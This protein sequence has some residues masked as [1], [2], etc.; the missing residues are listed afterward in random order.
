MN[1]EQAF[2]QYA[3]QYDEIFSNSDIG[4]A[5]RNQVWERLTPYLK[6]GQH[7]LEVNC[8]TG[9][10]AIALAEKGIQVTATDLSPAMIEVGQHKLQNRPSLRIQFKPLSFQQLLPALEGEQFDLIFSNFGGLNC[11]SPKE[12]YQLNN[13]FAQML[14][15]G[16]YLA[17]VYMSKHCIWE[18]FYHWC[19]G[20]FKIAKRRKQP[21]PIQAKV[22]GKGIDTWYASIQ[23]TLEYFPAFQLVEQFPIGLFVPPSYLN[24]YFSNRPRVLN[25]LIK[26][27]R[28][29]ALPAFA[30]YADHFMIILKR[31]I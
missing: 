19:K 11:L 28:H 15:P 27:D 26:L 5:Q 7:I 21:M 8:G 2:D 23:Q 13:D 25:M 9:V 18:Q 1:T 6:G 29:F 22:G 14:L 3:A 20:E 31:K 16:G 4:V 24:P 12:T 17:L 10:D 30:D